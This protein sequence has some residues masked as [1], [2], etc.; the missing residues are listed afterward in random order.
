MNKVCFLLN[1]E[2]VWDNRV[3]REA[4]TL[5]D[6]GYEVT[7]LCCRNDEKKLPLKETR[8][9]IHI[10]RIFPQKLSSYRPFRTLHVKVLINIIKTYSKFQYIHAHDANTLLLSWLLARFWGAKLI[11]DSHELWQSIYHYER[12]KLHTDYASQKKS[13]SLR[14]FNRRLHWLDQTEKLEDWLLSKCDALVSV[15][16]SITQILYKRAGKDAMQFATIRNMHSYYPMNHQDK[17]SRFH[18]YFSLSPETKV[19]L[20]QGGLAEIRGVG[21]LMDAMP[22]INQDNVVLVLMGPFMDKQFSVDLLAKIS[23]TKAL[24]GKVFYKETVLG[25][26]LLEWTAS[27]D[28]GMAPILNARESY[29]LCLPNKLFE[30]IQAG[31]PC[32]TSNFPE[33]QSLVNSYQI[34]FTFDPE[35]PQEIAS[36]INTFFDDTEQKEW[37]RQN[38]LKAKEELHWEKEQR[39]LVDLY[40]ALIPS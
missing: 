6:A 21:K 17:P 11:Y 12:K 33:M 13:I 39:Q 20:Y 1:N 24:V 26:E 18:K 27:A 38:V 10:H 2:F 16:E 25:H 31:L 28:L 15:N 19:V 9:G 30:Y 37:Y 36:C 4:R 32:G 29:Y 7:L 5:I 40:R 3:E 14:K 8:N 22:L 23:N 34:G 35:N